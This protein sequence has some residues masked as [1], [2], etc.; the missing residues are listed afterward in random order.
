MTRL[1]GIALVFALALTVGLSAQT[2]K[3]GTPLTLKA[4]TKVSDIYAN[5]DTFKGQRVQV[6]GPIVAVCEDMGCWIALGSDKESQ[7]LR[8]KVEDGVIV[9]PMSIKGLNATVEGV[10][11]VTAASEADQAK[12]TKVNIQ[13]KGEGA[14]VK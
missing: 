5:P 4:A 13:I 8:F 10:I 12:G 3:Y 1:A 7:T 2:K 11:E 9:F 6:Q 14:E